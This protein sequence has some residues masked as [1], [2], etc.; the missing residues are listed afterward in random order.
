MFSGDNTPKLIERDQNTNKQIN[1]DEKI[2]RR[3]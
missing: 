2:D 1:Y 3:N